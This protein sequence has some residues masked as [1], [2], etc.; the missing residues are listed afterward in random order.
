MIEL[1]K[2]KNHQKS[3]RLI[4]F[5]YK[6]IEINCMFIIISILSDKFKFCKH[7]IQEYFKR[8]TLDGRLLQLVSDAEVRKIKLISD[9]DWRNIFHW[10]NSY[11]CGGLCKYD[12]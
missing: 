8:A 3:I 5:T 6:F 1:N 12:R 7:G 9:C 10:N 2:I 4:N 11:Y